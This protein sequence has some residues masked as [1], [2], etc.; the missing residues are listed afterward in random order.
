MKIILVTS[1]LTYA[2]ENYNDVFEFVVRSSRQHIV[3]VVL[4]RINKLGVLAKLPYLYFA[5]CKNIARTLACNFSD[6]LLGQKKKFLKNLEIPFISVKSINDR[7]AILWLEA[8]KPDL[9][10]NMRARCIYKDAVL[11]IPH[12]GCV[13]VH[14]GILPHQKGFFCD[15]YALADNR[16]VG[17]TI[18]QMTNH[19]DQGQILY[20]EEVDKNKNYIDYLAG[21]AS[22]EKTA[23]VNFMERNVQGN[24]SPEA[25]SNS[26]HRPIVTTTPNFRTIKELQRKGMIL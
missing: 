7:K 3:G 14:H 8:L 23:I 26:K 1:D 11:K 25:I 12:L 17:F 20:R 9:I 24:F 5:G 6:A 15:L 22:R 13:N 2:P 4:V 18:H 21:V 10:F 19:V 16:T